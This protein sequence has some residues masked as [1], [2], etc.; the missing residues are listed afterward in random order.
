M[1]T[2]PASS[3]CGGMPPTDS[4]QR[5][6][7]LLCLFDL[8]FFCYYLFYFEIDKQDTISDTLLAVP[9]YAI[10]LTTLLAMRALGGV[11]FLIRFRNQH[12]RWEIAGFCGICMALAGW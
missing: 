2:P 7:L 12:P 10:I 8:A 6:L 11:L 9:H 5:F 1:A 3:S 4:M